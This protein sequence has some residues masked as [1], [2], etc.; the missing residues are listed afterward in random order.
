VNL[1]G[2]DGIGLY[3]PGHS[4]ILDSAGHVVAMHPGEYVAEYLAPVLIHGVISVP[5]R[6]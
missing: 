2:D 1:A 6:Q 3:H 5:S 4:L